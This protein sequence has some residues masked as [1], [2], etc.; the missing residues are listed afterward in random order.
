L[1]PFGLFFAQLCDSFASLAFKIGV[2]VK[3]NKVMLKVLAKFN[4]EGRN[5]VAKLSK[6][7]SAEN[8]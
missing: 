6:E 5:G 2:A 7:Y 4:R 3:V 8:Q 1:I